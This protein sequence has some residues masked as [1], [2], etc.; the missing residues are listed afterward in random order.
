VG[1]AGFGQHLDIPAGV[2]VAEEDS[3]LTIPPLNHVVRHIGDDDSGCSGHGVSI[4]LRGQ[5]LGLR[6]S[7]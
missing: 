1:G 5:S 3:L 7:P 4:G 6:N 2:G